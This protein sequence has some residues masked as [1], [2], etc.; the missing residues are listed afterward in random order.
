MTVKLQGHF[1]LIGSTMPQY[2]LS[3]ISLSLQQDGTYS[4]EI[5]VMLPNKTYRVLDFPGD[6]P[7]NH[8]QILKLIKDTFSCSPEDI[9]WPEYIT[10]PEI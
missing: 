8:G 5:T 3:A 1:F 6:K 10:I 9:I 2:K 7:L 4:R